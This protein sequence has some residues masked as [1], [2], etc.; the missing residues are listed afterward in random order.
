M[1]THTLSHVASDVGSH[2]VTHDLPPSGIKNEPLFKCT[3]LPT[4]SLWPTLLDVLQNNSMK[5]GVFSTLLDMWE[6]GCAP[7]MQALAIRPGSPVRSHKHCQICVRCKSEVSLAFF[8]G[9]FPHIFVWGSCFW[10]CI[11]SAFS[12][13]ASRRLPHNL[14]TH[15]LHTLAQKYLIE[16]RMWNVSYVQKTLQ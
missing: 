10:C 6:R 3:E 12:R 4:Q 5:E 11:P 14:L 7:D 13:S 16:L 8:D 15:N 1:L 9:I 2:V